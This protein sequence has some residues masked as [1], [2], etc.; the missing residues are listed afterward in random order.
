MTQQYLAGELSI[1]LAGLEAGLE[2]GSDGAAPDRGYAV[3]VAGLRRAAETLPV[4]ALCHIELRALQL[5]D[6]GCWR[7]LATGEAAR[8]ELLTAIGARLRE[9]GVCAGLLPDHSSPDD[10]SPDD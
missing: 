10:S 8:F 4:W 9:F 1:L 3:E 6:A 2:P 7:C 5:A